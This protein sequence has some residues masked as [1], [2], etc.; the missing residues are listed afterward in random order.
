MSRIV[1]IVNMNDVDFRLGSKN[2]V[3]N[4]NDSLVAHSA[5]EVAIELLILIP[6]VD[7]DFLF[8]R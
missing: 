1:T 4:K 2:I 7:D 6:V 8:G 5:V 3:V